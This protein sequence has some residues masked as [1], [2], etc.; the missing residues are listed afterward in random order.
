MDGSVQLLGS[1]IAAPDSP[2]PTVLLVLRHFGFVRTLLPWSFFI[3]PW[4]D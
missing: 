2:T 1:I 4:L 3:V